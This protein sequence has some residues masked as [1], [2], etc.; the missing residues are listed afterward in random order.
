MVGV[1]L[2]NP[3]G[4][5]GLVKSILIASGSFGESEANIVTL[6]SHLSMLTRRSITSSVTS[7]GNLISMSQIARRCTVSARSCTHPSP[8]FF[9]CS[10]ILS[11][12]FVT[13]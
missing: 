6:P 11:P 8:S 7:E 13:Q 9:N 1:R 4:D 10:R 2:L 12:P 3:K 5:G